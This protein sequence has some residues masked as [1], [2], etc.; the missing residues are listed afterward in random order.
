MTKNSKPINLSNLPYKRQRESGSKYFDDA[1]PVV[2][3]NLVCRALCFH[4]NLLG[5]YHE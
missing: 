3:V 5:T 4:L 1:V 2:V